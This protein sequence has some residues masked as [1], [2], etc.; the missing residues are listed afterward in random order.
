MSVNSGY[1]P[2]M[3]RVNGAQQ[4]RAERPIPGRTAGQV[5]ERIVKARTDARFREAFNNL[6]DLCD[7]L[8][9]GNSLPSEAALAEQMNVSRT[10]IRRTL[11]NLHERGLMRWEGRSK[12][13]V[14]HPEQADRIEL[15]DS[16]SFGELATRFLA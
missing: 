4:V 10:I 9:T 14:C 7:G 6:L 1:Q 16:V 15:R 12:T 2:R 13:L 8:A 11:R 5:R 3:T